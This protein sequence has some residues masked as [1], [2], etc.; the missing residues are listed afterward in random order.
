MSLPSHAMHFS[1]G[2]TAWQ[3]FAA[4]SKS[5]RHP[6]EFVQEFVEATVV[7]EISDL[8]GRR[9]EKFSSVAEIDVRKNSDHPELA[10]DRQKILD[11]A[12]AAER[13]RGHAANTGGLVNVFLEIRV[14]HML[15]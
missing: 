14:E 12:R 2:L 8:A 5:T 3:M 7:S 4:E 1:C 15:Q 9:I 6:D 10:Y 11:H 13:T